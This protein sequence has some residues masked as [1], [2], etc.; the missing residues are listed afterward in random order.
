MKQPSSW[1]PR[2]QPPAAR[3]RALCAIM[4]S[5]LSVVV[6]SGDGATSTRLA[7]AFPRKS[8]FSTS[9]PTSTVFLPPGRGHV[10]PHPFHSSSSSS[11]TSSSWWGTKDDDE[12]SLDGIRELLD[13]E[14][15][16]EIEE[17]LSLAR[18]S[19][20]ETQPPSSP[21]EHPPTPP[22]A[23]PPASSFLSFDADDS[24]KENSGVF[25][26][27]GNAK[28][29]FDGL[30]PR[31][32]KK[33]KSLDAAAAVAVV[34]PP[35]PSTLP[36]TV[37]TTKTVDAINSNVNTDAPPAPPS[38]PPTST[39]LN[40]GEVLRAALTK[41]AE[42]LGR[43]L[44]SAARKLM[45]FESRT[46]LAEESAAKLR[47]E[48]E[49]ERVERE[50]YRKEM[51]AEFAAERESLTTQLETAT[52]ELQTARTVSTEDV[53]AV[54]SKT[55]L[56]ADGLRSKIDA[57]T[58]SIERVSSDIKKTR[59]AMESA[60]D[61]RDNTFE[62]SRIEMSRRAD[63]LRA[64]LAD[65]T[66]EA[67]AFHAEWQ[68]KAGEAENRIN[69]VRDSAASMREEREGLQRQIDSVESDA[70]AKIGELEQKMAKDNAYY[71]DF[72]V[73]ERRRIDGVVTEAKER[74]EQSL[75]ERRAKRRG[76]QEESDAEL[77]RADEE[78]RAVVEAARSE[79]RAKLD[80]LAAQHAEERN[81]VLRSK[82]EAL[83]EA[84]KETLAVIAA[85]DAKL[86]AIKVH[87]EVRMKS[88]RRE[89]DALRKELRRG[90]RDRRRV[91]EEER[92]AILTEIYDAKTD[93]AARLEAQ[94]EEMAIEYASYVQ[95]ANSD[96]AR[97]DEECR[98]TWVELRKVR[99]EAESVGNEAGQVKQNVECT[100]GMIDS[101]ERD[102]DSF[103][104]S[105]RLSL[106]L[107][108]E[109]V[110]KKTRRLLRR[111]EKSE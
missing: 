82:V 24:A 84:R 63:R 47:E 27:D 30:Q 32:D 67:Q 108:K 62:A 49:R 16:G 71:A 107:A 102:K 97:S 60:D 33:R 95:Q 18:E 74:Y 28:E 89:A 106:R 2:H 93:F 76:I 55:N 40:F 91:A 79:A 69:E 86:A 43:G 5:I 73:K 53:S 19:L 20:L 70:L 54:E 80:E 58:T 21:E 66:N 77:A 101:H 15:A 37:T 98:R 26:A 51:E 14:L 31:V 109:K 85:E 9:S 35:P 12:S 22:A 23:D 13:A 92:S 45:D 96:I 46:E 29:N 56:V 52:S 3:A 100:T 64:N 105:L 42:R 10:G 72:L 44:E 83:A 75:E 39:A 38:T 110:G 1:A 8:C 94:R 41:E 90:L 36:P 61:Q 57:L 65:E 99:G 4:A 68:S 7:F 104:T 103:Q 87:V 34:S 59:A 78:G 48:I 50:A 81:A 111:R 88:A 17:A 25:D 11:V 6:A